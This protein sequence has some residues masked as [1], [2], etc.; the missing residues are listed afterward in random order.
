MDRM[1][2]GRE[3]D[4][5]ER[6]Q[7]FSLCKDL[8]PGET[9]VLAVEPSVVFKA[10]RLIIAEVVRTKPQLVLAWL[11]RFP[12][13]ILENFLALFSEE[14][15]PGWKLSMGDEKRKLDLLDRSEG[16]AG[17]PGEWMIERMGELETEQQRRAD[18]MRGGGR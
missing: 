17:S 13:A 4:S 14:V 5:M 11:S 6:Q 2:G 8:A 16:H 18:A 12:M 9:K 10:E 7:V 15:C 3:A 1:L